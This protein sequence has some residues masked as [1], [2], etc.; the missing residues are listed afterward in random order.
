MDESLDGWMGGYMDGWMGEWLSSWEKGVGSMGWPTGC[1]SGPRCAWV[2]EASTVRWK[3]GFLE[4]CTVGSSDG[5]LV[6]SSWE[7]AG[8][9]SEEGMEEE[10]IGVRAAY[11]ELG[12]QWKEGRSPGQLTDVEWEGAGMCQGTGQCRGA[13]LVVPREGAIRMQW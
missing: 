10:V 9:S 7:T 11:P 13:Q 5:V 12:L 3:M 1:G 4:D 8:V 6:E 2:R